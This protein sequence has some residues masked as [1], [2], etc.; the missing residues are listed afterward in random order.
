MAADETPTPG[1]APAFSLT[2]EGGEATRIGALATGGVREHLTFAAGRLQGERL[3]GDLLAGHSGETRL[4]RSDGVT[5]VEGLYLVRCVDGQV[6]R[7]IGTG[8]HT[9]DEA[10]AGT[11]MTLVIEVD[12][13]GPH[14]LLSRVAF[15][16]ER[17]AGADLMQIAAVV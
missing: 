6:L 7:L 10:F 12:E 16:A 3:S 15:L 9:E 13:A 4:G 5:V 17:P 14:A 11:R 1:L 8:Y 2:F